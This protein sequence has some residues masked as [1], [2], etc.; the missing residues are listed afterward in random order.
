VAYAASIVLN[1]MKKMGEAPVAEQE[2]NT[3]KRGFIDRFP[4]NFS[5]KARIA[6]IFAQ[7]EFTGRYAR[8][9]EYWAKNRDRIAA[10]TAADVQRV[11]RK[12]LT[13]DKVVILVVGQK[14][15]VSMKLPD[16]PV[17]LKELT[18]GPVKDVPLRDPMTMKP[19]T[20][21]SGPAKRVE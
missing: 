6:G 10:V 2:L 4:G 1:E 16:H 8:D 14:K 18:T 20:S 3:S 12:Y 13:P 21:G 19:T 11:A 9:P 17:E 7:D 15:E 5:T